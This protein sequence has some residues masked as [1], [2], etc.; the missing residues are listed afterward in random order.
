M[1]LPA[2]ISISMPSVESM[3]RTGIRTWSMPCWRRK[4]DRHHQ[5]GER[6]DQR[7]RLH[8]AAEGIVDEG[9]V[10]AQHRCPWVAMHDGDQ[11][12]DAEQADGELVDEPGRALAPDGAEHQQGER[13]DGRG[14][15]P[16]R[17]ARGESRRASSDPAA[18]ELARAVL[19]PRLRAAAHGLHD[20]DRP[21][22]SRRRGPAPDARRN[23]ASAGPAA[24]G[25]R[26]RAATGRGCL[27]A[28]AFSSL[29]KI[30]RR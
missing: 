25:S 29:P 8:E 22:P 12:G 23:R 7:Q 30:T 26:S 19:A 27:A 21:P 9:A 14:S 1:R 18:A 16:G 11:Q 4:R 24:P 5:R 10:E 17:A 2:E 20:A 28:T 13:T 3:I 15:I 6:A